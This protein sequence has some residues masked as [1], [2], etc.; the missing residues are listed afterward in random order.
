M[1]GPVDR[2]FASVAETMAIFRANHRIAR[3]RVTV[4]FYGGGHANIDETFP[5][6]AV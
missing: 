4:W 5:G 3:I 2:F 1:S 6:G